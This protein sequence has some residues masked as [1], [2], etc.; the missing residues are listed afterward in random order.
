LSVHFQQKAFGVKIEILFPA[1]YFFDSR[2]IANSLRNQLEPYQPAPPGFRLHF[3][4]DLFLNR[5]RQALGFGKRDL[6]RDDVTTASLDRIN[7]S[8]TG[9]FRLAKDS[10]AR[11][12][13][14]AVG[15]P[16]LLAAGAA[17]QSRGGENV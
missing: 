16:D 15:E 3:H 8:T 13:D 9:S 10:N 11:L 7:V 5:R 1:F 17:G 14:L 6:N 4:A 2:G 12:C